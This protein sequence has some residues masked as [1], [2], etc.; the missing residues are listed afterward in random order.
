MKKAVTFVLTLALLFTALFSLTASAVTTSYG[1]AGY[2]TSAY[3]AT[4]GTPI[5]DGVK[6]ALYD[7]S[8]PMVANMVSKSSATTYAEYWMA[9]NRTTLFIYCHVSDVTLRTIEGNEY[10]SN[11]DGVD[12]FID[13]VNG[14]KTKE[15][16]V[17]VGQS[18]GANSGMFRVD[19]FLTAEENLERL[20]KKTN[21]GVVANY[22]GA[23]NADESERK[24]QLAV[25]RDADEVGY[26]FEMAFD[27][28]ETYQEVLSAQ[29][30][31]GESPT[32]GFGLMVNNLSKSSTSRYSYTVSQNCYNWTGSGTGT[33][34][35]SMARLGEVVLDVTN[36]K[37]VEALGAQMK[38]DG[39]AVRVVFGVDT[40]NYQNVGFEVEQGSTLVEKTVNTVYSSVNGYKED[41]TEVT[42][43]ARSLKAGYLITLKVTGFAADGTFTV[44]PYV[45]GADGVKV[46][47]RTVSVTVTG[48]ALTAVAYAD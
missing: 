48:G 35:G 12:M 27:F 14:F 2:I 17:D 15:T 7:S 28:T 10:T 41:G 38:D 20:Y 44:K 19:P 29:L 23:S 45:T 24:V 42:Y 5:V 40:L 11:T 34:S 1:E 37:S 43:T 36:Y 9:F 6:D 18:E 3:K 26:W 25:G 46:Y 30:D 32:L 13:L 8:D 33:L 47:G 22:N 4:Y 21:F 16:D 31:A 39:N